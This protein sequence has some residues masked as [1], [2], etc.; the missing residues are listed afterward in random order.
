MNKPKDFVYL[1]LPTVGEEEVQAMADAVAQGWVAPVGPYLNLFE[2]QIAELTHSPSAIA[3]NSGTSALFLAYKL[4]NIQ[5]GDVVL[6][7]SFTFAASAFPLVQLG[8][9]VVFIDSDP[10]HWNMSASLLEEAINYF[11]KI[12]KPPKA[13]VFTAL[14]GNPN[15]WREIQ[16][17]A[18]THNLI[19]I[20]DAAEAFG[21]TQAEGSLYN[22][23]ADFVAYSFN[24]N[25]IITTSA[26]GAITFKDA[27]FYERALKLSTQA[28]EAAP[29]YL[30]CEVGYNLRLSNILAAM[31]VEQLKKITQLTTQR[32]ECFNHYQELIAQKLT[33]QAGFDLKTPTTNFSNQSNNWLSVFAG[34][35]KNLDHVVSTV[36]QLQ[37]QGY[38]AR[39]LWKPLHLQPVFSQNLSFLNGVSEKFF[40]S[41]LCLPSGKGVNSHVRF[42][43]SFNI[44]SE[45]FNGK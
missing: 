7:Q 9:E 1:S 31:G 45:I 18:Q 43:V 4:A 37:K 16:K 42:Q 24:G 12:G 8:A 40:Q 25:K 10:L 36:T 39:P 22:Y 21:A 15:G 30:H 11:Q 6:C 13:V 32:R 3:L 44:F 34:I 26:G 29:Y 23:Q 38:E 5:A 17:V 14:Y 35:C 33:I 28:K 2:Q 41:G 19:T 27:S 20:V